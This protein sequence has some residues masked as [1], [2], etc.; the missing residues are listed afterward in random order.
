V[1]I[2]EYSLSKP[3][4]RKYRTP[5]FEYRIMKCSTGLDFDIL[6]STFTIQRRLVKH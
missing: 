3:T 6:H 2:E 4:N 1:V 5:D